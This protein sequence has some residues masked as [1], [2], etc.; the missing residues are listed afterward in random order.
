MTE[1]RF[2]VFFSYNRE[3]Q[4]AVERAIKRI[5]LL[6]S[7]FLAFGGIP[8]LYYG[9]ETGTLN[10]C[11]F[12]EDESKA[13]DNRWMHRPKIDWEKAERRHQHGSVEQ[14][15]FD[16][17]KKLIAVRKSVEPF[18]D[19]NN[20]ELIDVGN[21]HLF[22]FTRNNPWVPL[23]SVLVVANFDDTPHTISIDEVVRYGYT[24]F[25]A[26]QDIYSGE[27]PSYFKDELVIPPFRFY[28]LADHRQG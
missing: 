23:E 3:D 24:G 17:I 19:F 26:L 22:V 25:G 21:P 27:S 11:T 14:R 15:I 18:A 10:D 28:W 7:M 6:H 13:N 9:D 16:G 20:R 4:E 1:Q 5:L 2:D 8:L 12:L